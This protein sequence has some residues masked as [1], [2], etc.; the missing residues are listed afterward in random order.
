MMKA[1][2]IFQHSLW[3]TGT[4]VYQPA[5]MCN[6]VFSSGLHMTSKTISSKGPRTGWLELLCRR[7]PAKVP[8][9]DILISVTSELIRG[10][11]ML[12]DQNLAPSRFKRCGCSLK[13]LRFLWYCQD[14]F[15]L[16]AFILSVCDRDLCM[17]RWWSNIFFFFFSGKYA[18][19]VKGAWF[20][21]LFF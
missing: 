17:P 4:H 15:Q 10:T 16:S 5:A 1:G 6:S 13:C 18:N 12:I 3:T 11:E 7:E 8:P 20:F 9:G 14:S 2:L 19:W 21:P